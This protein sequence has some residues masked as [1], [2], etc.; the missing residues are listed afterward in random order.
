MGLLKYVKGGK[1]IGV[2]HDR[3]GR[4]GDL[5]RQTA[6]MAAQGGEDSFWKVTGNLYHLADILH[7]SKAIRGGG[8][9]IDGGGNGAPPDERESLVKRVRECLRGHL[10]EGVGLAELARE[11]GV[12]ESS[13]SH[14]YK[15]LT[16]ESPM[17][18]LAALRVAEAKRLIAKGAILKDAAAR[19]GF[20]DEFHLS[21]TFKRLTGRPPSRFWL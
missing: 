12:S 1:G 20:C 4:L 11:V 18:T 15:T 3:A 17:R 19:T 10:A 5:L 7:S 14:Q 13:L 6:L 21:K 16:G 2:F 9:M 8:R